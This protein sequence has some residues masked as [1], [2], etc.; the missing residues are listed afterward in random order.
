VT[1][2]IA[3]RGA[4]QVERENTVAA[5]RR[6][7]ELGATWVELDVRLTSDGM[8]AVHHDAHLADGRAVAEVAA[9]DL[10]P[11]VPLLDAALDACAGMGVNVE[12]KNGEGEPGFDPEGRVAD[13]VVAVLRA[14]GDEARVLVSSFHLPTVDRLRALAPDVATAWL[15]V[16]LPPDGLATLVGHGHGA[17]H[18]WHA[19][20][21][22][23]LVAACHEQGVVV[24][25]WTVDEPDRMRLL[26]SW[27]VDGIC[28]N[29]PDVAVATLADS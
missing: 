16:A 3:H 26:A 19:S 28:T 27:G 11:D 15:V 20:V 12:L 22:R 25:V 21:T 13:A 23:E 4:S 5:F 2:V 1:T 18:P 8:L 10:P 6:A 17:L 24:N 29:V 14:R 9:A 7:R